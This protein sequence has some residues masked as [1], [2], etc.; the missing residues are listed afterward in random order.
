MEQAVR[1][2]ALRASVLNGVVTQN[3]Y[4]GAAIKADTHDAQTD[5]DIDAVLA[6]LISGQWPACLVDLS[7]PDIERLFERACF[8][9]VAALAFERLTDRAASEAALAARFRQEA[10]SRVIWELRHRSLLLRLTAAMRGYG[11]EPVC[12]KGTA[13][14][15][16]VYRQPHHRSRGDT[17]LIVPSDAIAAA[18]LALQKIGFRRQTS[19][20]GESVHAQENWHWRSVEGHV[21]AVDLHWRINNARALGDLFTYDELRGTAQRLSDLGGLL[22]TDLATSLVIAAFHRAVHQFDRHTLATGSQHSGERMCW[23]YD[24]HLLAAVLST[25]DWAQAFALARSKGIEATLVQS[26]HLAVT[27]FGTVI[28]I[29]C[30][31]DVKWGAAD[32]YLQRS[33]LQ[34]ELSEVFGSGYKHALRHIVEVM[35]PPADYL[36]HKYATANWRWL[37]WLHMRRWAEG[38]AKRFALL[39]A[40]P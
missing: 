40:S 4:A 2:D 25:D 39:R 5:T 33:Q 29:Q 1:Q 28:P 24:I 3:S 12:F 22:V 14:A 10:M 16:T 15:Y 34:R 7:E 23:L 26:L 18:R 19:L 21:H 37:P 32:R 11:V 8:H 30:V 38:C 17:D 36:R 27:R 13:L 20:P 31:S 35:L 9:G 6:A